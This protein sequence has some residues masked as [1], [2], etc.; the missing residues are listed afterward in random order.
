MKARRLSVAGKRAWRAF[1]SL[2]GWLRRVM[3]RVALTAA[4][5][6]V[7]RLLLQNTRLFDTTF[8]S[9]FRLLTLFV[10][11]FTLAYYGLK[12]LV[13]LKRMLLWRVR[14]RLIITYLFVGL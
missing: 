9:L 6:F 2:R 11:C 8:G 13:R 3:P 12:L 14:R 7:A 1:A 10:V 5:L 4:G